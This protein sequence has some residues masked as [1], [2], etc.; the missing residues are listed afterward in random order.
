MTFR[1]VDPEQNRVIGY[2]SAC[3][4]PN[5]LAMERQRRDGGDSR[6]GSAVTDQ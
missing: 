6:A 4:N 5:V 1:C 3:G 2:S